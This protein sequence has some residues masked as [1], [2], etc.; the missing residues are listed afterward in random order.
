VPSQTSAV[1]QGP[2]AAR[3]TVPIGLGLHVIWLIV[4][5][6]CWHA[7]TG[8]TVPAAK[9]TPPMAQF[10]AAIAWPQVPL[11]VHASVVQASPSSQEALPQQKPL[12]QLPLT[13]AKPLVHVLPLGFF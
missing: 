1:S 13:Q 12:R 2:A 10:V 5:V 4:G 11:L 9:Q 7:F 8:L 3:Q 6:H